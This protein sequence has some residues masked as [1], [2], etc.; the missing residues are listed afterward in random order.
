MRK[1]LKE[2]TIIF[3]GVL[4]WLVLAS[5]V[6][7]IV[8]FSTSIFLKI[9]NWATLGAAQYSYYFLLLPIAFLLS[10]ILIKTLAPEAEGHGTEK[11]IEAVHK[12]SGRIKAAVVPVKLVATVITLAFG[13][14]AGKEGPSAQIGAGMA[15]IFADFLRFDDVDRKKLVI[16]GIS[17]GFA[18]VFGTPVAGAIFG[19]EVLFVGGILYEVLLPSFVAGLVSFQVSSYMGISYFHQPLNFIPAFSEVIFL[20][21]IAAG[22]F[23]GVCSFLLVEGLRLGKKAAESIKWSMPLK[24]MLGGAVL[25]VLS[26]IFST[27]YLGLGLDPM[28]AAL[29]GKPVAP[30]AFILKIM[31]TSITLNFGGSGGIVTPIFF[32]GATAGSFIGTVLGASPVLFA[33]IGLVSLL[34]GCANTPIAASIM[35]AELFG[36]GVSSYAAVA[37]IISYII[38][39]HRSVYP[40][41]ILSAKKS[42]S[43]SVRFGEEIENVNPEYQHREKS[44]IGLLRR[45]YRRMRGSEGDR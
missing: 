44:L 45:A 9:L 42:S 19:V 27:Q 24:A 32:I 28:Q 43:L 3:I 14:S 31:F 10:T 36:S 8:G 16:C 17:G 34:S 41:Q 40:S 12:R 18:S 38:T 35:A 33:A 20:K 15:S 39:G 11:V 4:K 25:V 22:V 21:V 13:G 23:F 1:K 37:C 26:F 5:I 29:E 7:I 2:E 30:Y 6:G